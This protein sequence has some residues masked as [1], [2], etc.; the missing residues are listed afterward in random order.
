MEAAH[1]MAERNQNTLKN[2]IASLQEVDYAKAA[3]E[4]T[5]QKTAFEAALASTA[6]LTN[7]SLLDYIK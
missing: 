7:L 6:K 5:Q 1:T 4:L 2:I 3:T